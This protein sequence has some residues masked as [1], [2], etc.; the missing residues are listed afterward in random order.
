MT[1]VRLALVLALLVALPTA[2]AAR[3]DLTIAELRVEGPATLAT[4]QADLLWTG[5]GA[6]ALDLSGGLVRVER[7]G[8]AYDRVAGEVGVTTRPVYERATHEAATLRLEA[9]E[10]DALVSLR[11]AGPVEARVTD[12]AARPV[13]H[14]LVA[15]DAPALASCDG[16][17]PICHEALG[18]TEVAAADAT[19]DL[20]AD[21]ILLLHGPTLVVD[22]G[23][24]TVRYASGASSRSENAATTRTEDVWVRVVVQR[25]AGTL[26]TGGP[27]TWYAETPTL[28]TAAATLGDATGRIDDGVRGYLASAD[29][30]RLTGDLVLALADVPD[31]RPPFKGGPTYADEVRVEVTGDLA[32]VSLRAMP[33]YAS[34][35]AAAAGALAA[36]LALAG[37]AAYYWPL[38]QF[39][40]TG[41]LAPFYTRLRPPQLLDNGVRHAI[42]EI[43]RA[44]PGIS[45]RSVHRLSDQSWG[46]VVYHLRQLEKHHLVVSRAVGRTRNYYENHGKYR[47]MEV[48]LAC[49][50]SDRARVLARLVVA[51]PGIAQEELVERSTFPQPTT[52]YYVRKLKSAGL[53]EERRDGRYAR[54]HPTGDV[55][56]FLEMA[57]AHPTV[58]A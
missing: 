39:H 53:V 8:V 49:L 41:A 50:R 40:A 44:N 19:L 12:A 46:T 55:A 28:T 2:S 21:V 7:M 43:I 18:A 57:D 15:S 9:G 26:A 11:L 38:L 33:V 24:E 6:P 37:A 22:A 27:A 42:Y 32:T 20:P 10:G 56:R 45:A 36:L 3:G 58:E 48:Q 4:T 1:K 51:T 47:G 30:V 54:Y 31:G 52:S 23:G 29:E 34:S 5:T 13:A 35:P 16:T 17:T 14:A 25:A